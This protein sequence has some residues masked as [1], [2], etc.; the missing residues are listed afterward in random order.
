MTTHRDAVINVDFSADG[1]VIASGSSDGVIHVSR[2]VP[3]ERELLDGFDDDPRIGTDHRLRLTPIALTPD[4]RWLAY[5]DDPTGRLEVWVRPFS[6]PSA[7]V[8]VSPSGGMEPIWSHSGRELFYREGG[9]LMSVSIQP[10]SELQF[11]SA[12]TLF[13]KED[14]YTRAG[15]QPPTYDVAPDGRFLF[16]KPMVPVETHPVTVV[17]N[18]V[19]ELERRLR[20]E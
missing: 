8:R 2:V 17:V 9:K 19:E 7:A 11:T 6:G 5:T 3:Q 10:G 14:V 1:R 16:L 15:T 4:G 13:D 12:V 20:P 18:W